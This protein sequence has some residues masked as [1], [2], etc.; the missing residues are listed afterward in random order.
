M[1]ITQGWP[2]TLA[3]ML[4]K[5][6]R[7]TSQVDAGPP[8]MM[9]GP[10]RAPSSPPET[11]AP[12]KRRPSGVSQASRRSVSVNRLLPPSMTMSSRSSSGSSCSMTES[13]A[14]PALTMSMILRGLARLAT[15]AARVSAPHSRLPG[16]AATNSRVTPTLRLNTLTLK[17]RLSTLSTRFWPI[18]ARPIRPKSKF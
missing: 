13:T 4:S 12:M 14:A 6:G 2:S 5:M 15:N 9:D 1:C 7:I 16:W 10:L 3:A 8:G 18:T 17:P 11:P